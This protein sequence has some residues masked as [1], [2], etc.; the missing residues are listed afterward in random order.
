MLFMYEIIWDYAANANSET[1]LSVLHL[2]MSGVR[3]DLVE[4]QLTLGA[5]VILQRDRL[6]RE[7]CYYPGGHTLDITEDA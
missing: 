5:V 3:S 6:S 7:A 1:L 2:G 4:C